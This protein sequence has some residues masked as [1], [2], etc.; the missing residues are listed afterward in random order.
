M[1]KNINRHYDQ[2]KNERRYDRNK[3]IWDG[4]DSND[5]IIILNRMK[6]NSIKDRDE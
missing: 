5:G 4:G 1:I 3:K 2:R 6:D